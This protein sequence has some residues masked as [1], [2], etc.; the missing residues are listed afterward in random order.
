[1]STCCWRTENVGHQSNKRGLLVNATFESGML[2]LENVGLHHE[3]DKRLASITKSYRRIE[4]TISRVIWEV[5]V[6]ARCVPLRW[7]S[8]GWAGGLGGGD[9]D[10]MW[11]ARFHRVR[12]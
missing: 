1:M 8:I 9:C 2:G 12:S 5:A 6:A 10:E 4:W 7:I 11:Y 3:V